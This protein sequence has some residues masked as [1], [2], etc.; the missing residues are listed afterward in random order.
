MFEMHSQRRLKRR[1]TQ[2]TTNPNGK[3]NE[4]QLP[5]INGIPSK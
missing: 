4:Q 5:T 2:A 3:K 1:S